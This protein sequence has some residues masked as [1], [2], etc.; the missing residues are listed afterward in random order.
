ME[1]LNVVLKTGYKIVK[2]FSEQHKPVSSLFAACIQF[3]FSAKKLVFIE[4][5]EEL[6]CYYYIENV[7][8]E[9]QQFIHNETIVDPCKYI[10]DKKITGR[11]ME[12]ITN[13]LLDNIIT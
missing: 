8:N 2:D 1:T 5:H 7:L 11:L 12:T 3:I 9:T 10:V 13:Y 4:I 6:T